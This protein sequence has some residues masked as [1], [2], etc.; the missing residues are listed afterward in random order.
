M[1]THTKDEGEATLANDLELF[2]EVYNNE[3]KKLQRRSRLQKKRIFM[4][5][6]ILREVMWMTN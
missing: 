5:Y 1:N 3:V 6:D 2:N 4:Y